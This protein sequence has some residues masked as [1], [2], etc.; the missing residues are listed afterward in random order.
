MI[1]NTMNISR[2]IL[3]IDSKPNAFSIKPCKF[4]YL[5]R[6]NLFKCSLFLFKCSH[7]M[8]LETGRVCG[9]VE[10]LKIKYLHRTPH[11]IF[12]EVFLLALVWFFVVVR[13]ELLLLGGS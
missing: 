1:V 3:L 10:P 11:C 9:G 2:D 13:C 8:V 6:H 4:T 7:L 5:L 12:A